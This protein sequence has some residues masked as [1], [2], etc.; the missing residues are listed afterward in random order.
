[1][2]T[3]ASQITSLTIVYSTVFSGTDQ[4][5]VSLAFVR[6]IHWGPVN[7]PHKGPVM[8]KILTFDDVIMSM[9]E[10]VPGKWQQDTRWCK[11]CA[12]FFKWAVNCI[13][14][15]TTQMQDNTLNLIFFSKRMHRG[16]WI[17]HSDTQVYS[18]VAKEVE[19]I[20]ASSMHSRGGLVEFRTNCHFS[21][22]TGGYFIL[23]YKDVIINPI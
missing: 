7:S 17:M 1:M 19:H 10:S 2:G 22:G 3:M 18:M 8:R 5:S 11:L 12:E 16:C 6:G 9:V 21:K 13:S 4:S 23:F 15:R 20:E 14:R